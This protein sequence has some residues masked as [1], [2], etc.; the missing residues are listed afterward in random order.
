MASIDAG[1]FKVQNPYNRRTLVVPAAL[2]AIH[3]IVFWSKDFGRFLDQGYADALVNRGYCLFFNFTINSEHAVLEPALPSLDIRLD[4]LERLVKSFG[5]DAVQWRFDPICF[6]K[7][8][9]PSVKNNLNQFEIIARHAAQ[10]GLKKCI[11]SFVDL[12]RKVLQRVRREPFDMQWVDPP[13][14]LK[15]ETICRLAGFLDGLGMQLE[16]CCEKDILA[17]LPSIS[18]VRA[19]SCIPNDLLAALYGPGISL[20]RDNSQRRAAGC[21]CGVSR[22]IGSYNLHPCSHNC[23]FCYANPTRDTKSA[24]EL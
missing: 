12:Y 20:A 6:F 3:S 23:L 22:D 10:L 1:Y 8:G 17:A 15:V 24:N 13:L 4:Q 18:T 16:L 11:T 7:A 21:T 5:P 14:H 19:A 9:S 2:G